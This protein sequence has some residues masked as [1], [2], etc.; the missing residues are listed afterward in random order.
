ME[1]LEISKLFG[2]IYKDKK[3]LVTGHTGFKG[4]WLALWLKQMG[5]DVYGLALE[6]PSQPNHFDLLKL[7]IISYIQDICDLLKVK[8]ICETVNPDII[9]HLAA[10]PLVRLSYQDPVYTYMTNVIG[11]V[12][13]L[14]AS[15]KLTDLK[16]IVVITSD[17][18]YDN[19]EWH[20]GYRENEAMGGKDPYSSSKGCSEL[21]TA[22]Y[23]NSFFGHHGGKALV[24]S[25]RAG[26]VIGGGD[27][28]ADRIVTDVVTAASNSSSLFLRYPG[29]TRPWQFVLEPL[30]GYLTLGWNLLMGI[31]GFA[32]SWN[33]GPDTGNNVTVLELVKEAEKSWDKVS[34]EFDKGEHP[35]EAGLLMLDSTKAKIL[36]HWQPVWGFAKTV[37]KTIGW[38]KNYYE[39]KEVTS[40]STL[41]EYI[42]DAQKKDIPWSRI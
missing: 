21:V 27:W 32:E 14:E 11:T 6:P 24:A 9:F 30:S 40:V 8:K 37:Q 22:A 20:W 2:G 23:R 10:Q 15:R 1:N 42:M 26:N 34:F 16:A 17:K 13:I 18:C 31:S 4:S 25:A 33:F 12:N 5:A 28:A 36:L 19:R 41:S 7:D 29:A 39:A 3:V 35:H 38:Y